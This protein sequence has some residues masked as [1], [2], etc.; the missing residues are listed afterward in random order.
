MQ[1]DHDA[2]RKA[3]GGDNDQ[4]RSLKEQLERQEV[5]ELWRL[6]SVLP[7]NYEEVSREWFLPTALGY[8]SSYPSREP[9]TA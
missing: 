1:Y 5:A 3:T 7:R 9:K 8:L 2:L 6:L 4:L